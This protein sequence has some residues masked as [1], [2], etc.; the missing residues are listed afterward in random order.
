MQPAVLGRL[1]DA[2][3]PDPKTYPE[4]DFNLLSD[5]RDLRRLA[6][7]VRYLAR[8]V[9][10][11]AL[12]ANPDDLFPAAFSP[13]IKRLSLLSDANRRITDLLGRVLDVPAPLRRLI[14]RTFMLG[15]TSLARNHGDDARW[16]PS[17]G[18]MSSASGIRAA[19][20]AWACHPTRTRS[21]TLQGR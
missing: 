17:S 9:I 20:A 12:N 1:A 2:A 19:R 18:A 5:E 14:L 16:T 21:S 15:G 6:A 8:L 11:S 4:V 13:R 7:G 10:C 3:S